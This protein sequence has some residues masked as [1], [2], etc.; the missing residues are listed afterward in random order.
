MVMSVQLRPEPRPWGA[1]SRG[2]WMELS[3]EETPTHPGKGEAERETKL[4]SAFKVLC[5]PHLGTE[6]LR[7]ALS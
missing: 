2:C 1:V 4:G 6:P 7:K 5:H 3:A